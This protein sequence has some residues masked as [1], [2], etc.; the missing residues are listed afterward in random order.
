MI[1]NIC[2]NKRHVFVE[3]KGWVRCQCA[4]DM[5]V[6]RI[7]QKSG[8][9][10]TLQRIESTK[11]KVTTPNKKTLSEAIKRQVQEFN[12]TPMFIYSATLEKDIVAAIITRY[13]IVQHKNIETAKYISLEELTEAFFNKEVE[14]GQETIPLKDVDILTISIGK[15][16]TNTA[17]KN[18]LYKLLYDRILD[19]RFTII[20]SSI[21]KIRLLSR[22]GENVNEII[23]MYFEFYEC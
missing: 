20:I 18:I 13:S 16:I 11:F 21:P 9:P 2:N 4:E 19:E 1:C 23:S 10:I 15:E 8:I 14:E 12:S 17:H 5:R 3:G 7:M 22:Y 6:N